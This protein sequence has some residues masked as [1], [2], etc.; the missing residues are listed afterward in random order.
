MAYT[1]EKN[2]CFAQKVKVNRKQRK[3]QVKSTATFVHKCFK[4]PL[5]PVTCSREEY[6]L[7][8][9]ICQHVAVR[10]SVVV[11]NSRNCKDVPKKT[12]EPVV[13]PLLHVTGIIPD[14]V[15]CISTTAVNTLTGRF[16]GEHN[17]QHAAVTKS[18]NIAFLVKK[19]IG[20]CWR[21]FRRLRLM[22]SGDVEENQGPVMINCQ[23]E[24]CRKESF[25]TIQQLGQHLI[26]H[27]HPGI[28]C[29]WNDC[30]FSCQDDKQLESHVL[31]HVYLEQFSF[32]SLDEW[33][34]ALPLGNLSELST[35][36]RL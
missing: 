28:L 4:C 20:V 5:C 17:N 25:E 19:L 15:E 21:N 18:F 24:S 7:D 30:V 10:G 11:N 8:H 23:W 2:Q 16:Q 29:K 12:K 22:L 26:S 32:T 35:D 14:I 36:L 27:V 34:K 9:F 33:E 13:F 1:R 3:K 6:L 31:Q